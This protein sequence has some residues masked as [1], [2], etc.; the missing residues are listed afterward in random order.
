MIKTMRY[1][2]VESSL[3]TKMVYDYLSESDYIALQQ[4]LLEHPD[5]G[6]L[7]KGSGGVRKLRWSREGTG[8]SV[9]VRAC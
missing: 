5:A 7:V 2:F 1:Q 8:K 4:H 9:G 6:D 3:F